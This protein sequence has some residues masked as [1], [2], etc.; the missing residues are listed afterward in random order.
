[1][2]DGK[3]LRQERHTQDPA[4]LGIVILAVEDLHRSVTFHDQ[5]IG[6][7]APGRQPHL[8]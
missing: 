4:R 8:R 6:G 5:A 3:D 2:T 1:M 7:A